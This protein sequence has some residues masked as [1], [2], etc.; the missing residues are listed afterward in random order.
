MVYRMV[1]S[2]RRFIAIRKYVVLY[3][4]RCRYNYDS[5]VE[6]CVLSDSSGGDGG[7]DG[8]GSGGAGGEYCIMLLLLEKKDC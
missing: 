8:G 7:S 5:L 4:V 3:I 2:S 1:S 6:S